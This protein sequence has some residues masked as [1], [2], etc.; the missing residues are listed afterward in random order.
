M[1]VCVCVCVSDESVNPGRGSSIVTPTFQPNGESKREANENRGEEESAVKREV[2]RKNL[3]G[4]R[5]RRKKEEKEEEVRKGEGR[6]GTYLLE[7]R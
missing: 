6:D 5:R 7:R 3:Y 1:C 2:R 4:G